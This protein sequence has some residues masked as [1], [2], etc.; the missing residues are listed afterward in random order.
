MCTTFPKKGAVKA[1]AL[2]K[3]LKAGISILYCYPLPLQIVMAVRLKKKFSFTGFTEDR[4]NLSIC[5]RG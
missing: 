4:P 1:A 2:K 5:H 3:K